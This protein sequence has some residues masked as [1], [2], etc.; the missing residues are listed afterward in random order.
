L[1]SISLHYKYLTQSIREASRKAVPYVGYAANANLGDVELFNLFA[2][3]SGMEN[4]SFDIWRRGRYANLSLKGQ[5][6]ALVGGGTLIYSPEILREL[7]FLIKRGVNP[8]FL[9]TGVP[10]KYPDEVTLERWK[11][12]F[13]DAEEIWVRGHHSYKMMKDI[14]VQ[15]EIL[16]D[17]GYMLNLQS[18]EVQNHRDYAVLVLRAIRPTDYRLFSQ[19]FHTRELV[20]QLAEKLKADGIEVKILAVSIDDYPTTRSMVKS[21]FYGFE[22]IEYHG[23][24]KA[25][26]DLLAGARVVTS[27]RLHPGIFALAN[28]TR[29]IEL[30]ARQK[31][32]DSFN[33]FPDDD[34]YYNIMD[35]RTLSIESLYG[36]V[37][38]LW[39][40]ETNEARRQRF[41]SVRELALKQKAFCER[42]GKK[43][44]K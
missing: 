14:G 2:H 23:D 35:P 11:L 4:F 27:M 44:S 26:S 1:E 34:T 37:K 43:L 7:E 8:L 20:R 6:I 31:F 21:H 41:N 17:L 25:I 38:E 24:F 15:A 18:E 28:G 22:Y 39:E 16:G 33:V 42:V 40:K 9:G 32:H 3:Y 30:E 19:D 13:K 12:L 29:V 10:D 5:K 36:K